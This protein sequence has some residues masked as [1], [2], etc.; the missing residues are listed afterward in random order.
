M[1]KTL[2]RYSTFSRNLVYEWQDWR[3]GR[4]RVV[5]FDNLATLHRLQAAWY[6]RFVL[7]RSLST[8]KGVRGK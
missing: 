8:T 3:T 6:R 4:R 7:N 2:T 5:H 1:T